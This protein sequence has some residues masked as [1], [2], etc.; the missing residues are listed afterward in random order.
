MLLEGCKTL[1]AVARLGSIEAPWL[2]SFQ[3]TLGIGTRFGILSRR[4]ADRCLEI[5]STNKTLDIGSTTWIGAQF[6]KRKNY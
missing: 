6:R 4:I 5:C 3:R 1:G 2:L